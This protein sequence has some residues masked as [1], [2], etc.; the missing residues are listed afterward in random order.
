MFHK[1][2]SIACLY[3]FCF[4]KVSVDERFLLLFYFCEFISILFELLQSAIG[5]FV[6]TTRSKHFVFGCYRF[7]NP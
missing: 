6:F 3:P 7:N 4:P 5:I 1:L 2:S